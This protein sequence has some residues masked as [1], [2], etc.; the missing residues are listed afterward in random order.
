MAARTQP[1]AEAA[2]TYVLEG[3]RPEFERVAGHLVEVTG[4]L[5]LMSAG[6][7]SQPTREHHL[8][9]TSLRSLAPKCPSPPKLTR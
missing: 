4:A 6:T 2:V 7:S 3:Q 5:T 1:L 8:R 9:V